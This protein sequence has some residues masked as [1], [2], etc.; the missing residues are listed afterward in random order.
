[1]LSPVEFERQQQM[2]AEGFWKT[3]DCSN[4]PVFS[5]RSKVAEQLNARHWTLPD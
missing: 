3:R 4:G 5:C 2:S 1:M